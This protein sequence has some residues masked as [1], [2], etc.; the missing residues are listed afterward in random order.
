MLCLSSIG[1]FVS[2]YCTVSR[3]VRLLGSENITNV[4]FIPLPRHTIEVPKKYPNCYTNCRL[5]KRL[6]ED[7]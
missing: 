3:A 2:K 4:D 1:F 5:E 7:R 6:K